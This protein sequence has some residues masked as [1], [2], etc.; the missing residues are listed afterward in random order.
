MEHKAHTACLHQTQPVTTLSYQAAHQS[1]PQERYKSQTSNTSCYPDLPR[2]AA[3]AGV[4][5]SVCSFEFTF[6]SCPGTGTLE[7]LLVSPPLR[8][9]WAPSCLLARKASRVRAGPPAGP[10]S[11]GLSSVLQSL[12]PFLITLQ[13]PWLMLRLLQVR[14]VCPRLWVYYSC[15]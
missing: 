4:R 8:S 3:I 9:C 5:A 7:N 6:K 10:F 1:G 12:G 14:L 15:W 13:R 2:F 11:E